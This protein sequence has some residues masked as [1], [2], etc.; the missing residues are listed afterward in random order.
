MAL[1]CSYHSNLCS[2]QQIVTSRMRMRSKLNVWPFLQ[3]FDK[4]VLG[5]FNFLW[6]LGKK[7]RMLVNVCVLEHDDIISL[8]WCSEPLTL[9]LFVTWPSSVHAKSALNIIQG[10][11]QQGVWASLK[12]HTSGHPE[13]FERNFLKCQFR[14]DNLICSARYNSYDLAKGYLAFASNLLMSKIKFLFTDVTLSIVLL[15]L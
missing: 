4:N 1:Q 6:W 2:W 13:H 5:W 12:N 3:S 8:S 14:G 10:L 11:S 9:R 7:V 15:Q